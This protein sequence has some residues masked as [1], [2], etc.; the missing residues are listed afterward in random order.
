MADRAKF[1]IDRYFNVIC[2]LSIGAT[3]SINAEAHNVSRIAPII[4]GGQP[5]SKSA[6]LLLLNQQRLRFDHVA[7]RLIE[8]FA[9]VLRI[10]H[11]I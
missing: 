11:N 9:G 6:D 3:F 4:T 10:K 8:Q 7:F 5:S 1:C 2:R